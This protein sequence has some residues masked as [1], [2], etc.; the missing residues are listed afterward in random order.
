MQ[1]IASL[2]V[3][4][5]VST[6]IASPGNFVEQVTAILLMLAGGTLWA[7]VTGVFCRVVSESQPALAEF[8][9]NLDNLNGFMRQRR[10]PS[11]LQ[12]RLREYFHK[13][14]HLIRSA[15]TNTLLQK[16]S[17]SLQGEVL[18]KVNQ[19]WLR[20]V[21]FLRGC[22]PEFI[23]RTLLSLRPLV[24]APGDVAFGNSLYVLHRGVAIYGGR[25]LGSGGVW[26]EDMLLSN[27]RLRLRVYARALNYVEAFSID[28]ETM[29]E[30][31]SHFP[32]TQLRIRSYIGLLALR[33]SVVII[34]REE[35][36]QRE[37]LGI[38]TRSPYLLQFFADIDE[39]TA[40]HRWSM[41]MGGAAVHHA[42]PRD[43]LRSSPR[44]PAAEDDNASPLSRPPKAFGCAGLVVTGC[45]QGARR[46]DEAMTDDGSA[47][48]HAGVRMQGWRG[49]VPSGSGR[50]GTGAAVTFCTPTQSGAATAATTTPDSGQ[51]TAGA[52]PAA[53]AAVAAAPPPTTAASRADLVPAADGASAEC[54]ASRLG[55][56]Q[57]VLSSRHEVE[58]GAV[59]GT[60]QQRAGAAPPTQ[61]PRRR[62]R[63]RSAEAERRGDV[64]ASEGTSPACLSEVTSHAAVAI[65]GA[66]ARLS[67]E[68]AEQR[69]MLQTL[70]QM[71]ATLQHQP[72]SPS[73]L[74]QQPST[75]PPSTRPLSTQQ[76]SSTQQRRTRALATT[77]TA[78]AVAAVASGSS[79]S[80]SSGA[81][82]PT[83]GVARSVGRRN[84]ASGATASPEPSRGG[85]A[86]LEA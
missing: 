46:A 16:M 19:Q 75:Q 60:A 48:G 59:T 40:A 13:T 41:H 12:W 7:Q 53:A 32:D 68:V 31:S 1:Y 57:G 70:M 8:R 10:L 37:R 66:I 71:M 55:R 61:K 52:S 73:P 35:L 47:K 78:T 67:G 42:R 14:R 86:S 28:R 49:G 43:A 45:P 77:T 74:P 80:G 30:L 6:I 20:R 22:E 79:G 17:P 84:G 63:E 44:R 64:G 85:G 38:T 69:S 76:S 62:R 21:R 39:A 34:A 50:L 9:R 36:K 15:A 24:F 56:L 72:P 83:P 11:E 23:A 29:M 82:Q 65:T 4:S 2:Y 27:P 5:S 3:V 54:V 26:G 58:G 25:V 33:R 51:Q 18:W 81:R